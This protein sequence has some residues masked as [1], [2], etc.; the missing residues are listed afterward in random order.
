[1]SNERIVTDTNEYLDPDTSP[2]PQYVLTTDMWE[3]MHASRWAEMSFAPRDREILLH[4]RWQ[5]AHGAWCEG[6]YIGYWDEGKWVNSS[7]DDTPFGN[8]LPAVRWT[9][10]PPL[11]KVD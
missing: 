9:N 6:H 2:E 3:A 1:M 5:D 11:D 4:V 10:L 7:D 8:D